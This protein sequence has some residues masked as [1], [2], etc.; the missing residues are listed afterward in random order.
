MIRTAFCSRPSVS[1][2]SDGV[3][4]YRQVCSQVS[5]GCRTNNI[6]RSVL[7]LPSNRAQTW[8]FRAG[9]N[10]SRPLFA[11]RPRLPSN[12][13]R[14][15]FVDRSLEG[16]NSP[17]PPMTSNPSPTKPIN[18][19][20]WSPSGS[21]EH[22]S[23]P[24][25]FCYR[26]YSGAS[27]GRFRVTLAHAASEQQTYPLFADQ[28]LIRPLSA[29]TIVGPIEMMKFLQKARTW[30]R[31]NIHQFDVFHG[32]AAFHITLAP[33]M[34]AQRLGVPAAI[35][36]ASHNLEF[37][38]KPGL[39]RILGLPRRRRAMI[40][41]V[42]A[43]IAMSQPIF[44]ELR[45]IGV[46]EK[47]IARIPMGVDMSRFRPAESNEHRS[48]LRARLGWGDRFTMAF[49][50]G[51]TERKR[52]HLFIEALAILRRH[53]LD[54]QVAFIGPVHDAPY[55]E[56]I[57]QRSDELRISDR[58]IWHGFS[59]DISELLRA[60]DC[61]ALPS[62]NEGMPAAMVEAMASG[63]PVI[64]TPISGATDLIDEGRTG[65]FIEPTAEDFARV[66]R[67]YIEDPQR[68]AL[69]GAAARER[70]QRRFSREVVLDAYERMFRRIMSGGDAAE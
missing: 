61:F 31:R 22:Y 58:V 41:E 12:L 47:R 19:L 53:G 69:H 62:S 66:W 8:A 23:G 28:H 20:L 15:H 57:K 33:A 44:D 2:V 17:V 14:L 60:C 54:A 63:L 5:T 32:L 3:R 9:R 42:A 56:S 1:A 68:V 70:V 10:E 21:G 65:Y 35:F 48:S 40:R 29:T 27:P 59:A 49:V 39:R 64:A 51:L 52:P 50:G 11:A 6:G 24:G 45:S 37:T 55:V 67:D 7:A 16:T 13:R 43:V 38:D 26:L 34:Q 46:Q 4:P 30:T 18:V 25:S 36:I